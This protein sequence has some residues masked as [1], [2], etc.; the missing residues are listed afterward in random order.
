MH[1]TYAG[2]RADLKLIFRCFLLLL[3]IELFH[4]LL[5]GVYGSH[6]KGG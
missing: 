3:Q 2:T 6:Q 1:V 5:K 4:F